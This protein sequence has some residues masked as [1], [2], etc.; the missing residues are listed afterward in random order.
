MK[1]LK[2]IPQST[3]VAFLLILSSCANITEEIYLNADGSGV[4]MAYTD[5][6][7]STRTMMMGMMG[8]VYPDA[9]E[10]SLRQI[11]EA[12]LWE[13]FPAEVDS[14]ID[15]SSRVPDSIKNDPDKKKYLD[16]M[17]MFMKGSKEK[18]YLNSGMKFAFSSVKELQEFN[19]FLSDNQSASSVGMNMDI[20]Q[21]RVKFDFDGSSFSRKVMMPEIKDLSD[22]TMMV[23]GSL[24]KE[25]K[26]RLILH[27][28]RKADK[29]SKE[30]LVGKVGKDVTYEF[31]LIKLFLGSQSA[32]V[33]VEF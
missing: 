13:Q 27:L 5:V 32:D 12:Q 23:I 10:D 30:Q 24:L 18:G 20:P 1:P 9:S 11:V 25:S 22:S 7:S 19:D 31:E 21:M 26:S 14:I 17:E 28:P 3:L 15:F 6:V 16:K 8:S 2:R 29:V 33:K 4:Y